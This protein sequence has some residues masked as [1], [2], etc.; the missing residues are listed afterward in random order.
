VEEE[1][2]FILY[3]TRKIRKPNTFPLNRQPHEPYQFQPIKL[4]TAFPKMEP[5]PERSERVIQNGL[6]KKRRSPFK[7]VEKEEDEEGSGFSLLQSPNEI[8]RMRSLIQSEIKEKYGI[9]SPYQ[10]RK[11]SERVLGSGKK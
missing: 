8:R 10:I 4:E 1:S 5:T 2:D 3:S 7:N 11:L 9:K 6:L